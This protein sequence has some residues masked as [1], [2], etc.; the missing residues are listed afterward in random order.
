VAANGKNPEGVGEGFLGRPILVA[1][2]HEVFSLARD[3]SKR[4]T[5]YPSY[6]PQLSNPA[7]CEKHLKNKHN[8]LCLVRK[9][10]RILVLG[11]Y[12]FLEAQF[13]SL[14]VN[15]SLLRTDNVRGQTSDH[16]SAPNVGYC[17]YIVNV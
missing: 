1:I 11:H 2:I 16:I 15:C 9:Y 3:W 12:L 8:S 14:L 10:A 6:I 7:C 17:L 13:S 4:I 5:E